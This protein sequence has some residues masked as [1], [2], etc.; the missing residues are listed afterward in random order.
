M[1]S[2]F[3]S[4]IT[5][6]QIMYYRQPRYFGN[7]HC[8]GPECKDN[9]CYGWSIAW[10]ASEVEKLKSAD[11]SPELR[12]L[13][14]KSFV[15]HK[16]LEDIYEIKFDERG[17]CPLVT[18]D[19]WCKI[20]RELG[21]EYMSN[22]CMVYPRKYL[23]A[24]SVVVYS[25]CCSSCREVMSALMNDERAMDLV[26]VPIKQRGSLYGTHDKEADLAAHPELKYRVELFDFFYELISDKRNDVETNIILGALAAQSLTKLVENRQYDR[27]PEALKS[28]KKQ[29]HGAAL[30]S[31]ENIKPNYNVRFGLVDKLLLNVVEC[32][33]VQFL[34]DSTGAPNLD[35]YNA[36]CKRFKE[37]FKDRPFFLRNLALNLLFEFEIPFKSKDNT[38][39]EN[40][41]L[42]TTA[43]ACI[44]LNLIAIAFNS[45]SQIT[46]EN[47]GQSF[48]YDTEDRFAGLTSIICRSLCQD[49]PRQ[50]RVLKFLQ[51]NG[52]TTPAYLALLV[53]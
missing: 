49:S 38:I 14:E 35:Y 3:R 13:V 42:F 10:K 29:M 9:C 23:L 26:N 45:D 22:T 16:S 39:F 17:K 37:A 32:S 52:L 41:S 48:T 31:V 33:F 43:Y 21:V 7:F 25:S 4:I 24:N 44:K 51:S 53:K 6:V 5:E 36:A 18:N 30:R 1:F 34:N 28:F 12:K 50:K 2:G 40:Y 15:P 20:Q 46:V 8:T 47:E 19:G 11:M 27:I